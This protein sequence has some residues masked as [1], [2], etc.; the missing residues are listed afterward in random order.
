MRLRSIPCTAKVTKLKNNTNNMYTSK[1]N[2]GNVSPLETA[3]KQPE[4]D[5]AWHGDSKQVLSDFPL[6][7]KQNLG[8]ALWQV[9]KGL[10]PSDLKI[11]REVGK[12]AF[13]LRDQ[14]VSGWYRVIY[15]KPRAGVLHVLH[16]FRKQTNRTEQKD[17]QTARERLKK[18]EAAE[19]R[20][21]RNEKQRRR[22]P[23]PNEGKRS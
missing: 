15:R 23:H 7:V 21:K 10:T 14:D 5:V 4:A 18:V 2:L 16:C 3:S 1:Q 22:A 20:E 19:V 13:E 17:I 12:G 6:E 9:Q 8:Y 11:M